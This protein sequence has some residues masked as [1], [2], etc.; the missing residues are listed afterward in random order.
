MGVENIMIVVYI[1]HQKMPGYNS[2]QIYKHVL[3]RAK[4]LLTTIHMKVLEAENMLEQRMQKQIT[5]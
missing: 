5:S 1:W 2:S 4:D 3:E